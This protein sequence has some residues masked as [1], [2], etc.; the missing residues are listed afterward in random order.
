MDQAAARAARRAGNQTDKRGS[1]EAWELLIDQR[2]TEW[3]M[4]VCSSTREPGDRP[5]AWAAGSYCDVTL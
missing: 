4:G 2:L 3:R 1:R 5:S